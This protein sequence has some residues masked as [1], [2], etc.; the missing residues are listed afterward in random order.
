MPIPDAGMDQVSL[1]VE[2]SDSHAE[3]TS[4]LAGMNEWRQSTDERLLRIEKV[5]GECSEQMKLV[6]LLKDQDGPAS[7]DAKEVAAVTA[8]EAAADVDFQRQ[9]SM[10]SFCVDTVLHSPTRSHI[11]IAIGQ[12]VVL[13]ATQLLMVFA[14]YDAA[15]L[16]YQ[17]QGFPPFASP[18]P[19][20]EFYRLSDNGTI[21]D[22]GIQDNTFS[23]CF[24]EGNTR[25][26]SA[27]PKINI[28][29]ACIAISYLVIGPLLAEDCQTLE[30]GTQP[31]DV[32][33][34]HDAWQRKGGE[35]TPTSLAS[36]FRVAC[37]TLCICALQVCWMV[38]A[39]LVPALGALGTAFNMSTA[40][41]AVDIVLNAVAIAYIYEVDDALYHSLIPTPKMN[42][43]Q[44]RPVT[45]GEVQNIPGFH[46][47][48]SSYS[49]LLAIVN[50][51]LSLHMYLQSVFPHEEEEGYTTARRPRCALASGRLLGCPP[52]FERAPRPVGRAANA[53]CRRWLCRR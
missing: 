28:I 22:I 47:L 25:S 27:Q 39:L 36:L 19:Q 21:P 23:K 26:C 32:L 4:V 40:S 45:R 20:A 38:R 46:Q 33:L 13:S 53:S 42:A 37:R 3:S 6:A 34:V 43:Y 8:G 9:T 29:A 24:G 15:L 16:G 50:I 1:H 31:L 12:V 48:T 52:P 44:A 18:I 17:Q 51:V 11:A 2:R 41:S 35:A 14:Y 7:G 10:Y 5:L 49:D 30:C